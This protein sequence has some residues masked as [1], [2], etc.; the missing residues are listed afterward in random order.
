MKGLVTEPRW[1]GYVLYISE[2]LVKKL[3]T[4]NKARILVAAGK[5]LRTNGGVIREQTGLVTLPHES[6][7]MIDPTLAF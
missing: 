7:G 1:E 3:Y 5:P 4:F 6:G 2:M